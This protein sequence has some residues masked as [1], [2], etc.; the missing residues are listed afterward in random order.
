M[1]RGGRGPRVPGQEDWETLLLGVKAEGGHSGGGSGIDLGSQNP[2]MT[3]HTS[4]NS[5]RFQVRGLKFFF[6]FCKI[7]DSKDFRLCGPSGLCHDL[8][9]CR[10]G[11]GQQHVKESAGNVSVTL[12]LQAQPARPD[13][14]HGLQRAASRTIATTPVCSRFSANP[15]FSLQTNLSK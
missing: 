6:F 5:L 10:S 1:P 4:Q 2:Q 15:A 11:R 12:D 9:L 13:V 3:D 7:S 14:G 8:E